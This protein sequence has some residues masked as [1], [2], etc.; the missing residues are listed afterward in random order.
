MAKIKLLSD[1]DIVWWAE[2]IQST[3]ELDGEVV[4]FRY[5]CDPNGE[6]CFIW[7]EATK[8]WSSDYDDKFDELFN[9]CR[10]G[11]ANNSKAGEEFDT[12]DYI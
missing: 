1:V 12:E 6:E 8:N 4:E 7:D 11:I 2:T 10:G 3:A 9:A 5:Y